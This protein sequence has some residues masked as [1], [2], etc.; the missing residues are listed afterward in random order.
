MNFER[1]FASQTLLATKMH[2]LLASFLLL[3]CCLSAHETSSI[4]RDFNL[5]LWERDG[6]WKTKQ[7]Q[8]RYINNDNQ[9]PRDER[10]I[11]RRRGRLPDVQSTPQRPIALNHLHALRRCT[12]CTCAY[13]LC[14]ITIWISIGPHHI[15]IHPQIHVLSVY[16]EMVYLFCLKF[17]CF[18]QEW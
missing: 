11:Q 17:V 16:V 8:N 12:H 5:L 6:E 7:K 1:E 18:V 9:I 3:R 4:W 15:D 2:L 13:D 14:P 10:W